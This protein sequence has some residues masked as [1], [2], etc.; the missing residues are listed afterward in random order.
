ML[1]INDD[2]FSQLSRLV[3]DNFGIHL[4]DRKKGLVVGRLQKLVL[5]LG[6]NTFQEYYTHLKNDASNKAQTEL[7][8]RISTNYSYFYRES[9][10][11][12]FF[13]NTALPSVRQSLPGNNIKDLRIWSAGCSTGEEPYTL[14]MLMLEVFGPEYY[15]W[16]IGILA[17]DISDRVIKSAEEAVYPADRLQRLP[18]KLI[19]KYFHPLPGSNFKIKDVVKREVTFRRLNLMN[20]RFPFKKPFHVIFCRNVMIYFDKPTRDGLI[21]RF[22]ENLIPG[23]YLFIGHSETLGRDNAY[24]NYVKPAVYRKA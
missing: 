18:A 11:F 7:I 12:D 10:H 23:G 6:F 24:L 20:T 14:V 1:T 5:S 22:Y 3:Y 2:E 16:D 17:T 13:T 19:Q 21:Q 8:N 4:T 15:T 9:D